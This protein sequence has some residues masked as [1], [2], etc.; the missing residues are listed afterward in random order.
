MYFQLSE[1]KFQGLSFVVKCAV[2]IMSMCFL[3]TVTHVLNKNITT[4]TDKVCLCSWFDQHNPRVQY[5]HPRAKYSITRTT[6]YTYA[7]ANSFWSVRF[8][9]WVKLFGFNISNLSAIRIFFNF[10]WQQRESLSEGDHRIL[11][12]N[13]IHAFY[14]VNIIC[15]HSRFNVDNTGIDNVQAQPGISG[16]F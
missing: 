8:P 16:C 4:S 6:V 2:E 9:F 15:K 10:L 3:F 14:I 11:Y 12:N 1:W 7:F 5:E 13:N